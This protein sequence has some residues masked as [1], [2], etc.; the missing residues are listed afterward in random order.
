[1]TG[2]LSRCALCALLLGVAACG[3]GS[4]PPHQRIIGA[5]PERGRS[6]IGK[7]G[8]GVCHDIPGI[9]G[10]R[11]IVGPSLAGFGAR[12]LIGGVVP[13]RPDQLVRWIRDAPS[14]APNTGMPSLPLSE[15]DARHVAAYLYSLR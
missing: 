15:D 9:H 14:L 4:A 10:A 7:I 3:P 13:N 6:M 1:M 12:A 8:C 2:L 11:G 5:N